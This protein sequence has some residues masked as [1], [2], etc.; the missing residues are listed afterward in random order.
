MPC[1]C[2]SFQVKRMA[3]LP[4]PAASTGLGAGLNTGSVP[5]LGLTGSP[6]WRP[7]WARSSSQRAQGHASRKYGKVYEL[8]WPSFHSMSMPVPAVKFTCTDRG[9]A[10]TLGG[11]TTVWHSN[12]LGNGG[13][14][15]AADLL[16]D[17]PRRDSSRG[18]PQAAAPLCL[19]PG[20]AASDSGPASTTSPLEH[21]GITPDTAVRLARFF[22]HARAIL[23]EPP[24]VVRR[25]PGTTGAEIGTA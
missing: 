2:P 6:G 5:G 10:F 22:W 12:T 23:D 20:Q 25:A 14:G 18:V 21:R 19:C 17:P 1:S 16:G 13:S 4:T 3:Y 9:S 11:M 15:H 7:C 24:G 8:R